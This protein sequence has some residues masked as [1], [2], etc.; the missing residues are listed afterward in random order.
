MGFYNNAYLLNANPLIYQ[1]C[2]KLVWC[3]NR[4]ISVKSSEYVQELEES[5]VF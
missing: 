2:E 1:G 4:I 5:R 3:F